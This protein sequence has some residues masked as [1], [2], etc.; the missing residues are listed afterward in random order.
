MKQDISA[1]IHHNTWKTVPHKEADNLIKSTCAYKLKRLPD[2][3]SSKFKAKF[4]FRSNL[5]KN[6][7]DYFEIY[8]PVVSWS[9]I[10]ILL[11]LVL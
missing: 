9:T 3:T 8:D 5:Q 6:G 10:L 11:K 1:H 4:C 7:I 2:E